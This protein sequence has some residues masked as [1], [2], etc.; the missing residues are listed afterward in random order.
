MFEPSI[1]WSREERFPAAR[2]GEAGGLKSE[3]WMNGFP[4]KK[5]L[6][7]GKRIMG[8]KQI[9]VA[10]HEKKSGP[11]V[12]RPHPFWRS[13]GRAGGKWGR[14]TAEDRIKALRPGF[15]RQENSPNGRVP[16]G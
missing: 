15:D 12:G 16:V 9:L 14:S 1:G 3:F 8:G 5:N 13:G 2:S 4:G 6:F 7:R 10:E 11:A